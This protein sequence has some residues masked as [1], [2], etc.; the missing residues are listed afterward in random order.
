M[1]LRAWGQRRIGRPFSGR[2]G[3]GYTVG[4]RTQGDEGVGGVAARHGA[5]VGERL[6]HGIRKVVNE[7]LGRVQ[8][9]QPAPAART[10]R[11]LRVGRLQG[12]GR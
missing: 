8:R 12:T 3:L 1:G 2:E 6:Q 4:R 7:R 11:R 5:R 10:R 9:R